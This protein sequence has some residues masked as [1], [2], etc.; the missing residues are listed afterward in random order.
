MSAL[1]VNGQAPRPPPWGWGGIA[2]VHRAS[3]LSRTTIAR[4]IRELDEAERERKN[5]GGAGG[6]SRRV[7]RA[8]AGRP[9]K[10]QKDPALLDALEALVESGACGDPES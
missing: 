7:R 10:T 5:A 9:T 6:E 2:P 3:G 4:G 1:D 8:G